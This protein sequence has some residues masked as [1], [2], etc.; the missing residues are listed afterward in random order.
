MSRFERQ[1]VRRHAHG[2]LVWS[3]RVQKGKRPLTAAPKQAK[4][5]R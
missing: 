1:M 5:K 3:K 2:M 4:R